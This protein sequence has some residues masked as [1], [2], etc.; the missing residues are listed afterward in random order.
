MANNCLTL[1]AYIYIY[2]L[3]MFMYIYTVGLTHCFGWDVVEAST[4]LICLSIQKRWTQ[5]AY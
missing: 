4:S 5:S 3:V 1:R 2:S